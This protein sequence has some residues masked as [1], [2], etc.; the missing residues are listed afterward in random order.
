MSSIDNDILRLLHGDPVIFRD[1]CLIYSPTLGEIA[2]TGLDKF[3]EYLSVTMIE[4]PKVTDRKIAELLKAISN[5]E[6]IILLTQ[7]DET[8]RDLIGR[9][10]QFFTHE[11]VQFVA[12][13][14]MIVFGDPSEK[15][16]VT[17]DTYDD[18]QYL[19]SLACAMVDTSEERIEIFEDDS[20]RVKDIK[21]K[22]LEGR[23]A[24]AKA[25]KKKS[26]ASGSDVKVSDLIASLPVG[27][28]GG[29]NIIDVWNL[30]YYAFQ[31]QLK[32]MSWR[33]EYDINTRAA[34]AGAKIDKEKL[35][36]WIKTMTFN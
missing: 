17:K 12:N 31:D 23:K 28:N 5:F 19:I 18:F 7:M 11:Q 9:A 14:P 21:R 33:E 1:I 24:R 13:P 30:T 3:Y 32:R 8:Q 29:V 22:M 10:F 34:M 4:K 20:P 15:R 25:K 2:T 27:S 26:S 36:H 16:V 6:Y 35:S